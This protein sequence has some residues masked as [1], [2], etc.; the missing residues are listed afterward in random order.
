MK[1]WLMVMSRMASGCTVGIMIKIITGI[2]LLTIGIRARM[3]MIM[4]RVMVWRISIA[5]LVSVRRADAP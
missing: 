3:I 2:L 1:L 5:E 4:T